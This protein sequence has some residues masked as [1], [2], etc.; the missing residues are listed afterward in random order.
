M[1]FAPKTKMAQ[2]IFVSEPNFSSSAYIGTKIGA[3]YILR[4]VLYIKALPMSTQLDPDSRNAEFTFLKLPALS[5]G[6]DNEEA[7][8]AATTLI[9][10]RCIK[11][12]DS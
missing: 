4:D 9:I 8:V 11:T 10:L 1:L 5:P 12:E 7:S 2:R 3:L 6:A